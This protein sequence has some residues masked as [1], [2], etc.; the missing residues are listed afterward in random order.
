MY[1]RNNELGP[2]LWSRLDFSVQVV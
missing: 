1:Y 2:E